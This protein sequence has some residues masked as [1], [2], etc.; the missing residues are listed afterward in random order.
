MDTVTSNSDDNPFAGLKLQPVGKVS[1]CM[2]TDEWL[3]KKLGKLNVTLVEGYLSC[4]SEADGLL[5][6]QFI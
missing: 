2:P 1:V 4:R 3:C 5:K 6:D